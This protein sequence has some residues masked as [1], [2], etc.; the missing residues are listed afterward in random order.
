MDP[1]IRIPPTA[2]AI[3]RPVTHPPGFEPFP[4]HNVHRLLEPGPVILIATARHG[5][6][7]V[8]T[9]GFHMAVRHDPPLVGCVV[10]PWDH[11]YETLR[12]TG[13]CVIGIPPAALLDTVVDIGNCSGA[14]VDKF[15]RFGLTALRADAVG[16]PL[17]GDC[18]ANV[19]C[20]VAD[21]RLVRPYDVWLL[22]AIR[23]WVLPGH[24][25]IP[26][27]HHRGN[28]TFV[29]DGEPV[30]RRDRMTK[31]PELAQR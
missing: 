14:T 16:P 17:I 11:T 7:N 22:E 29:L 25:E 31:W 1:Q 19:E 15:D 30:D 8:M 20:R 23:A 24:Q 21:D 12:E 9:N 6:P 18:V 10:G 5:R 28:G 3:R 4:L 13:E 27:A 26:T 2:H